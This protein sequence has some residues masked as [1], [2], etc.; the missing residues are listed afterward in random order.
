MLGTVQG[1]HAQAL[2]PNMLQFVGIID[3]IC[4]ENIVDKDYTPIPWEKEGFHAGM[5]MGNTV[6][7]TRRADKAY[8]IPD[9]VD[10][11]IRLKDCY[12]NLLS[13]SHKDVCGTL[14]SIAFTDVDFTALSLKCFVEQGGEYVFECGV[15]WLGITHS[16]EM[17]LVDEPSVRFKDMAQLNTGSDLNGH[18][19]FNTGYPYDHSRLTGQEKAVWT[20]GYQAPNS[21]DIQE[22]DKG[23]MALTFRI[24]QPAVI[25]PSRVL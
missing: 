5:Q 11:Y 14:A 23:E 15:P 10:M 3:T 4:T 16:K 18:V 19:L 20:L 24:H 17:T 13:E 7:F 25:S 22:L 6:L 1:L 21:K 2:D 12:G 8:D 9:D